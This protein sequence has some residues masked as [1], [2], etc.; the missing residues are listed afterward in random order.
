[1][2]NTDFLHG[3]D[4][5]NDP[6]IITPVLYPRSGVV[7]LVGTAPTHLVS[8][9]HQAPSKPTIVSS[10]RDAVRLFGPLNSGAEG[11]TLPEALEAVYMQG[12]ALCLVINVFDPN[13][14]DHYTAVADE[15]K[16]FVAGKVTLANPSVY[17]VVVKYGALFVET[18]EPDVDYRLEP[19]TGELTVIASGALT[20][21]SAVEVSYRYAQPDNVL[22]ADVAGGTSVGGVRTG[23]HAFEDCYHLYGF[24]P[25]LMAAPG[26]SYTPEVSEELIAVAEKTLAHCAIDAPI[27]ASTTE[28]INGRNSVD[29]L[30]K[31]FNIAAGRAVLCYPHLK[32]QRGDL[33]P[34]SAYWCGVAAATQDKYGFWWSPSN[35]P[36]RGVSGSERPLTST[37][38]SSNSEIQLLNEVGVVTVF[39]I[40]PLDS[41]ATGY[42]MWGNR[43]SSYPSDTSPRSFIVIQI[44]EDQIRIGLEQ[45]LLQ[46]VDRPFNRVVVGF[47]LQTMNLYLQRMKARGILLGGR[48]FFDEQD[49]PVDQLALGHI[50]VRL[51]QAGPPPLERITVMARY[52]E[53]YLALEAR[54]ISRNAALS[55]AQRNKATAIL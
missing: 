48:A 14:A 15:A 52:N 12:V 40:T 54:E 8:S 50:I 7:G 5:I 39:G 22:A 49:N 30:V 18:A 13:N 4:Y 37:Y 41:F 35:K 26:W 47:I 36:I 55:S 21:T 17:N 20:A 43:A 31:N 29:G 11:F 44:I 6:N 23:I 33:V 16:T 46:Y 9:L 19:I 38:T 3:V 45:A 10:Y 51:D 42:R 32:N 1:M 27:G 25:R 24:N 34:L 28:V 53:Q 2:A